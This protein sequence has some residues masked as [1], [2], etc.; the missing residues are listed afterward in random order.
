MLGDAPRSP[1]RDRILSPASDRSFNRNAV[2]PESASNP[3]ADN[4][5]R[6]AFD[7]SW[8]RVC[9]V[10]LLR[11]RL[12]CLRAASSSSASRHSVLSAPSR[13]QCSA[14]R[15]VPSL[16]VGVLLAGVLCAG[17]PAASLQ[18]GRSAR[19]NLQ[20]HIHPFTRR[21]LG[22]VRS[23]APSTSSFR[24]RQ[25]VLPSTPGRVGLETRGLPGVLR[26]HH[27]RKRVPTSPHLS[28]SKRAS[29]NS[30]MHPTRFARG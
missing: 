11:P 10:A 8:R 30:C 22:R 28:V 15:S 17:A 14:Q 25:P 26:G 3:S 20:P 16:W 27:P 12:H 6:A 29:P 4:S 23:I 1:T 9:R 7:T 24:P 18:L 5:V 2:E 19:H 13:H 21:R